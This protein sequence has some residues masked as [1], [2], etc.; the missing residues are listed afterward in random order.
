MSN[1]RGLLSPT[2]PAAELEDRANSPNASF[3]YVCFRVKQNG[4]LQN[5][6][7]IGQSNKHKVQRRKFCNSFSLHNRYQHKHFV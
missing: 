1:W 4:I 6:G 5:V 7:N 3:G 2:D